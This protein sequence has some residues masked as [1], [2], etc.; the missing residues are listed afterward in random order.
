MTAP[1]T[2]NIKQLISNVTMCHDWS[3]LSVYNFRVLISL[4]RYLLKSFSFVSN[5]SA[6]L[7]SF[8]I[9]CFSFAFSFYQ[10]AYLCQC[11]RL[12]SIMTPINTC[13]QVDIAKSIWTHHVND[14]YEECINR[15]LQPHVYK[16]PIRR[17]PEH[18]IAPIWVKLSPKCPPQRLTN[19]ETRAHS[20]VAKS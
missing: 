15:K 13:G 8:S 4:H 9:F 10:I 2:Q 12:T 1:E 7:N 3:C 18:S 5:M 11:M 19:L 16:N 17:I 14:F 6:C 20:L